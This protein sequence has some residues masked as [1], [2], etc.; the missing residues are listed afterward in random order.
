MP[1]ERRIAAWT[2]LLGGLQ[3]STAGVNTERLTTLATFI[4]LLPATEQ[5]KAADTIITATGTL[6]HH[7][8]WS[9]LTK[10]LLDGVPPADK[11]AI[12]RAMVHPDRGL[13]GTP[14]KATVAVIADHIEQLPR[15]EARDLL[16]HIIDI[17]TMEGEFDHLVFS[18]SECIEMLHDLHST[19]L[20]GRFND[21][22]THVHVKLTEAFD[23][24]RA[25]VLD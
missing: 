19:C 23:N 16:A 22:A 2:G 1:D 24:Y 3:R 4:R 10:T 12:A 14:M 9:E 6:S 7:D 20:S 8:G 13:Y 11:A 17:A 21:L 15:Q 5:R 25:A 18:C